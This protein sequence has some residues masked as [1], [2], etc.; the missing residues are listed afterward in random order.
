LNTERISYYGVETLPQNIY[1]NDLQVSA[2]VT[3]RF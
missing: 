2:V 3:V 1:I